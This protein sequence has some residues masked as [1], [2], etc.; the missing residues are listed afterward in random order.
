MKPAETGRDLDSHC[1]QPDSRFAKTRP[2]IP[3]WICYSVARQTAAPDPTRSMETS[4]RNRVCVLALI[5]IGLTMAEATAGARPP[6][7]AAATQ[8]GRTTAGPM[9]VV[10]MIDTSDGIGD[11]IPQIRDAVAA[12][13][14]A[15]PPE[16]ELML[17]AMGRHT[18]V[19]VP[20]TTDRQKVK[21]SARGLTADH[22]PTPLVDSLMEIDQRFIRKADRWGAFVVITGDGAESS[23]RAGDKEFNE[24]LTSV[25]T[26]RISID[27]IVL[28]YHANGL[29]Q[30]IANA[31]AR[32]S[33]GHVE[34][35]TMAGALP[36]KLKAIAARLGTEHPPQH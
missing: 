2:V 24:W 22:G 26:R 8:V 4:M 3:L 20:P 10:L 34:N 33:G 29:P 18:A 35:T 13:A 27:S 30:V 25:S 14:D 36:E 5:S 6:I 19:R 12:F 11:A 7:G 23:I 31:A 15:L 28:D 16:H 32:A 17:V 21:D 1:P 9:R